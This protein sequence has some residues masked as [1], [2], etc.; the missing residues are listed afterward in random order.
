MAARP[1]S[2]GDA[3]KE[4]RADFVGINEATAKIRLRLNPKE[5][6]SQA[7][8]STIETIEELFTRTTYVNQDELNKVEKR[9]VTEVNTVLKDEWE[10]VKRGEPAYRA[11]KLL[12]LGAIIASAG[13]LL[14][15]YFDI[16]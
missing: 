15:W 3:W 16:L 12:S 5:A 11:A 4:V 14:V 9:L 6:P 8:L 13:T 1:K 2:A 10:R 7:V